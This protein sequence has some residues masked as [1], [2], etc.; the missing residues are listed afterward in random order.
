MKIEM[1]KEYMRNGDEDYEDYD[2][3]D[4]DDYPV[5]SLSDRLSDEFAMIETA[6][7]QS[8]KSLIKEMAAAGQY[9]LL[10]RYICK[11]IKGVVKHD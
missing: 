4:M 3:D 5:K 1:L 9:E 7:G 6:L 2:E 8:N 10:G 11:M